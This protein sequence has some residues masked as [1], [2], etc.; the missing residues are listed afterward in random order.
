MD[1]TKRISLKEEKAKLEVQLAGVPQ[2]QERLKELSTILG[3]DTFNS[4]SSN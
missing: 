3:E 4:D 2:A 1:S